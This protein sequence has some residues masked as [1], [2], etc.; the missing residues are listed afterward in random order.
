MKKLVIIIIV[1]LLL[2]GGGG[3]AYYYFVMMKEQASEEAAQE[4]DEEQQPEAADEAVEMMDDKPTAEPVIKENVN[5]YVTS[6][7]L[8]VRAYPDTISNIRAVLQK[9]D[10]ITAKEVKGEWVRIGGYEVH[11]SGRDMAQWVYIDYL[12]ENKPEITTEE[13]R[14]MT[15][16]LIEKSDDFN[17]YQ[18]VFI[19]TTQNLIGTG[20]CK[21]E[22]FELLNGWIRSVTFKEQPIYFIYCGGTDHQHKIYLNADTGKTYQP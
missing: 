21:I 5:Y 4:Q 18:D 17:L 3:G 9:G 19:Q 11:D 12:S 16:A 14:K 20:D 13:R 10:K 15:A 22:D 6:N 7:R 1:L 2:A 8:N